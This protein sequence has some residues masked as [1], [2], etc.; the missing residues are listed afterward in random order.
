MRFP[1]RMLRECLCIALLLVCTI[2]HRMLPGCNSPIDAAWMRFPHRVLHG[3]KSRI[4]C[5]ARVSDV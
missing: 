3:C 5:F 1:H 2:S 4:G